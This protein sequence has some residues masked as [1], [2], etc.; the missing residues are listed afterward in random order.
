MGFNRVVVD[1]SLCQGNEA[2]SCSFAFSG[3][4]GAFVDDTGELASWAEAVMDDFALG[5]GAWGGTMRSQIGTGSTIDQ[6][7]IYAY[8]TPGSPAVAVGESASAGSAGSGTITC[9]PQVACVFSLNT[10]IPG[11]RT[12]G[13]FYW[14]MLTATLTTGGLLNGP[15]TPANLALAGADMLEQIGAIPGLVPDLTPVVVSAAGGLIT[16]VISVSIDTV[17]DTQRRRRDALTGSKFT[18]PIG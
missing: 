3:A 15:T 7:R 5:S 17:L 13:R 12:R 18:S 1:G 10:G 14:P 6:V 8:E 4:G 9:P 2:F 16:P 11:R